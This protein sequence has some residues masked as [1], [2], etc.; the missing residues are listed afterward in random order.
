M[1][2]TTHT[3]DPVTRRDSNASVRHLCSVHTQHSSSPV[4]GTP[5]TPQA[6]LSLRFA[7]DDIATRL[8]DRSHYGPLIVQKPLYPEGNE[9]CQVVVVHPPGGVVGGDELEIAVKVDTSANAQ[10]TT[11]GAA[12]WYR[13]NGHVSRQQITLEVGAGGALEWVP[14]ETIF[15][16]DVDVTLDHQ[17]SLAQEA[18]YI[19]CEILC[20]GRTAFGESFTKGRITQRVGIRQAGRL[21][22]FE[23]LHILGGSAAMASPLV[24]AGNTVCATLIAV[25]KMIPAKVLDSVREE[26]SISANGA[27]HFGVSQLKS[28]IVVRY[29]GNSSEVARRVMLASWGVLRPVMLGR[30]A[31][32]PRMWNT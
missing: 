20:F 3:D 4:P 24:L 10:I 27:G 2:P 11:P 16:D 1:Y 21:V 12:K 14:Q 25:G 19:G 6:R 31:M 9:V 23:Q 5:N 17:V 7:K 15:F 13:A 32:I 28:V 29:L 18:S 22:W 30:P 8:V 26:A